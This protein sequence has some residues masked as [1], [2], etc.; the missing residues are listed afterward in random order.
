MS[1]AASS[2]SELEAG[3]EVPEIAARPAAAKAAAARRRRGW[4][5]MRY[6][7]LAGGVAPTIGGGAG[8]D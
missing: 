4:V 1:S 6:S 8:V 2:S 3:A 5:T 7:E